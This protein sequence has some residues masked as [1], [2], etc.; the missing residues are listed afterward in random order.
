MSYYKFHREFEVS[1]R[2]ELKA[3]AGIPTLKLISQV[4][5]EY[6]VASRQQF[7]P[8]EQNKNKKSRALAQ[9]I[10]LCFFPHHK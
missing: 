8:T 5:C 6:S 3:G 10:S 9:I 2:H 1:I 7:Q 4:L